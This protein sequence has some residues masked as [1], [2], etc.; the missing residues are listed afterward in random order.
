MFI[1]VVNYDKEFEVESSRFHIRDNDGA[2]TIRKKK[3]RINQERI[4]GLHMWRCRVISKAGGGATTMPGSSY[5][6]VPGGG[7]SSTRHSRTPT[8]PPPSLCSTR[9][10]C[11]NFKF[12]PEEPDSR[13]TTFNG[14]WRPLCCLMPAYRAPLCEEVAPLRQTT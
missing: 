11:Q 10:S 5:S 12:S 3:L 9:S 7:C 1:S 6:G 8:S 2:A 4:S 13:G 14:V